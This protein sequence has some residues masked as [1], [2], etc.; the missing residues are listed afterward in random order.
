MRF[1][2][3]GDVRCRFGVLNEEADA[4]LVDAD[5]IE[6]TSPPHWRDAPGWKAPAPQP[7]EF[8]ITLNG[9]DY[10]APRTPHVST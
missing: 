8:E 7:V 10:L 1:V 9:Q 2:P 5:T 3:L 4:T 6:C